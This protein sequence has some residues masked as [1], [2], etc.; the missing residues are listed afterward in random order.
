MITDILS[1]VRKD[2]NGK[3]DSSNSSDAAAAVSCGNSRE[4]QL[5]E[6]TKVDST[7]IHLDELGNSSFTKDI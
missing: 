7:K 1:S 2:G 5:R 4:D 6:H 3:S